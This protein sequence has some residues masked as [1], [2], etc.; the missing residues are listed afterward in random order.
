M[1]NNRSKVMGGTAFVSMTSLDIIK[2]PVRR[3]NKVRMLP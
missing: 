2:F 3:E 1:K